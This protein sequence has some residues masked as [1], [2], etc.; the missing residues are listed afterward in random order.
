MRVGWTVFAALAVALVIG[1]GAILAD[2]AGQPVAG[3]AAPES[4]S[5]TAQ[6]ERRT[7]VPPAAPVPGRPAFPTPPAAAG[8]PTTVA[9]VGTE[10]TI[11]CDGGDVS[12]SGVDNTVV[13]TGACDRVDVSGVNNRVRVDTA[14]AI[15]VSGLSNAVTFG[16]GDPAITNSGAGNSVTRG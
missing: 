10:R 16:A 8:Q 7:T 9:G 2:R 14:A 13:L 1:G 5:A 15:I 12:V 3:R 4:G 6:P 11:A